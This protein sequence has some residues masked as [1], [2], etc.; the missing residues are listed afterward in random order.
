ML[1]QQ[2]HPNFSPSPGV[3]STALWFWRRFA[4]SVC[5]STTFWLVERTEA[6]TFGDEEDQG[7]GK[8]IFTSVGPLGASAAYNSLACETLAFQVAV[9]MAG[10][11]QVSS[12]DP[13]HMASSGAG[14]WLRGR[15]RLLWSPHPQLPHSFPRGLLFD[16]PLGT[17]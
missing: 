9:G 15:P 8:Q 5:T 6:R 14:A 12:G 17:C 1:G 10:L 16:S 11:H 13:I 7:K 4:A 2:Q 3:L